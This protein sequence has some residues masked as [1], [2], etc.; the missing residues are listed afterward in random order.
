[1]K[2]LVL[3][4]VG[5][6]TFVVFAAGPALAS[7]C[8]KM[9]ARINAEAGRRFDNAAYDAKM[10]AAAASKLHAEGKHAESEKVAQ[11]GLA[12]LGLK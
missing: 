4:F 11:E 3:T 8:P 12:R 2:R 10:K 6:G 1:M 5:I 9:I 7:Q